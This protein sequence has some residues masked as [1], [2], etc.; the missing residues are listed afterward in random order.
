MPPPSNCTSGTTTSSTTTSSTTTAGSGGPGPTGV[1]VLP[2]CSNRASAD[3]QV[4]ATIRVDQY[5][6]VRV[7]RSGP[8]EDFYG[9]ITQ[10]VAV[11]SG[12]KVD[13]MNVQVDMRITSS[14]NPCRSAAGNPP[15]AR[16]GDRGRWRIH[17]RL[18]RDLQRRCG[19]LRG[20]PLHSL[21]VWVGLYQSEHLPVAAWPPGRSPARGRP[22]DAELQA[23][24]RREGGGPGH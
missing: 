10:I 9:T 2:T 6:G 19:Q 5:L 13:T 11:A 12:S 1:S 21:S 15:H 20:G 3:T 18:H 16:P 17:P 23:H 8:H 14:A 22:S 4:K 24:P 7:G